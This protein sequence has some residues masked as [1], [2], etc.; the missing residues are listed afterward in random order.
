MRFFFLALLLPVPAFAESTVVSTDP[1]GAVA[2]SYA[3]TGTHALSDHIAVRAD[4]QYA[5][6]TFT[7]I[8]GSQTWSVSGNVSLYLDRPFH[9]PFA[10][11]GVMTKRWVAIGLTETMDIEAVPFR[12]IG[13]QAFVGWQWTFPSGLHLSYAV[14][15]WR[16]MTGDKLI[17][18]ESN[19]RVGYAW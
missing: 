4:A 2:R 8:D 11:V 7:N 5:P 17:G 19:I 12:A 3:V 15:A 9:G 10:E 13:P 16:D 6:E 1:V 14:G 18:R